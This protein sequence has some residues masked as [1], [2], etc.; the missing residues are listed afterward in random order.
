MKNKSVGDI[1]W[2]NGTTNV[3]P[4][5]DVLIQVYLLK[6]FDPKNKLQCVGWPKYGVSG[7][8]PISPG[9]QKNVNVFSFLVDSGSEGNAWKP[10]EYAA[11]AAAVKYFGVKDRVN[12]TLLPSNLSANLTYVPGHSGCG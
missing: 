9:T 8:I 3:K 12:F 4:G 7:T 10:D 6:D 11:E 2:I 5:E 1:F